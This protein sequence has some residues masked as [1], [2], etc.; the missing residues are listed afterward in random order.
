MTSLNLEKLKQDLAVI[1]SASWIRHQKLISNVGM[2]GLWY[3][4]SGRG[5][6]AL[7]HVWTVLFA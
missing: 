3:P 5:P 2:L 7:L 4:K 6:N 1:K